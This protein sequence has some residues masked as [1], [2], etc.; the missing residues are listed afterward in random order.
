MNVY[1]DGSRRQIADLA[2]QQCL[3]CGALLGDV[4]RCQSRTGDVMSYQSAACGVKQEPEASHG[5]PLCGAC[6]YYEA[7]QP[8]MTSQDGPSGGAMMQA[9][10]ATSPPSKKVRAVAKMYNTSI[11]QAE[12]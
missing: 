11:T 6:R 9:S 10:I 4:S 5:H 3:R 12:F 1:D 2:C 8:P 7:A